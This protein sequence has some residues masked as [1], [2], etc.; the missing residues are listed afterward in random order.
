VIWESL[1]YVCAERL[2]PVLLDTARQLAEW[3]ELVLTPEVESA[4]LYYQ[5]FHST[6]ATGAFPAGYSEAAPAQASPT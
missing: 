4:A 5:P 2:T 1:D 3:E 6:A